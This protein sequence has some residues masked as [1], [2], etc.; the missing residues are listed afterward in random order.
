M[1]PR[2]RPRPERVRPRLRPNDLASRPHEPRGLNIPGG[3]VTSRCSIEMGGRIELVFACRLLSIYHTLYFKEIQISTEVRVLPSGTLSQTPDLENFASA[4]RFSKRVINLDRERWTVDA[5]S[6]INWTVVGQLIAEFHYTCPTRLCRR[7]AS[8]YASDVI[9]PF[10]PR[11]AMLARY[12]L[13]SCVRLSL[14][15]SVISRYCVKTVKLR[16]TQT[17]PH[18]AQRL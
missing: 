13:S 3:L 4:Y 12:M 8:K 10:L 1:R 5:Q 9:N 17:T 18:I 2:S 11:D 16:I 15:P 6:V 14:C 7:P